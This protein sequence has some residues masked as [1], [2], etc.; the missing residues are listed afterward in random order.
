MEPLTYTNTLSPCHLSRRHLSP[1][2]QAPVTY[3]E[4]T[5]HLSRRHSSPIQKRSVTYPEGTRHPSGEHFSLTQKGLVTYPEGIRHLSRKHPSPTQKAPV[6]NPES[7]CHLP[8]RHP[9]GTH[10]L[11]QPPI[12]GGFVSTSNVVLG[13]HHQPSTRFYF[14]RLGS[15]PLRARW[16]E[17][18]VA[19][20]FDFKV[21]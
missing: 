16:W 11:S 20:L 17:I 12:P 8:R 14:K 6:T 13:F 1:I 10:H 3:P 21:H 7:I 19:S 4:G 18:I 5:R 15:L 9:E 2:Q